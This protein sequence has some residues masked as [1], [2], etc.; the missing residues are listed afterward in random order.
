MTMEL[1]MLAAAALLQFSLISLHGT[2]I[3][4]TAGIT[5]GVGRRD[6]PRE[7]SDLGRRIER[8]I[9]NNMESLAVFVPLVL[10]IQIVGLSDELTRFSAQAYVLSRLVF[11][12][13]Y[14]ANI[15]YLRTIMWLAGQGFLL[16][17]G[18]SI[19]MQALYQ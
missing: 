3:A 8:T 6:Q 13:L 5:W 14:I 12:I 1:W 11:A 4:L 16:M 18:Y 10:V 15:P 2:H 19:V 7:I 17:L 9:I